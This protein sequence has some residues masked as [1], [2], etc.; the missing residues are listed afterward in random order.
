MSKTILILGDCHSDGNN[1][2]AHQILNND[3]LVIDWSL[4]HHKQHKEVIVWMLNQLKNQPTQQKIPV[5]T[6]EQNAWNFLR[7]KELE[8]AWPAL[9]NNYNVVNLS[10]RGAHFLGHFKHLKSYLQNNIKPDLVILT[11]THLEHIVVTLHHEGRLRIFEKAMNYDASSWNSKLYD[12]F[13]HDRIE[14]LVKKQLTKPRAWLKR[15]FKLAHYFLMRFLQQQ[16]IPC[17][18]M[19]F[20]NFDPDDNEFFVNLMPVDIDCQTS[21]SIYRPNQYQE[22]CHAKLQQQPVIAKQVEKFLHAYFE[23]PKDI[24]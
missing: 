24:T 19:T 14:S 18:Y 5:Q 20:G 11:D 13:T 16:G 17:V 8:V 10:R 1:C 3:D 12:K 7:Q 9:I 2:L 4:Q 21:W 6:L 22:I 23:Q 15:R